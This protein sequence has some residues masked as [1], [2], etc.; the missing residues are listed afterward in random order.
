LGKLYIDHDSEPHI[1]IALQWGGS[2]AYRPVV[3]TIGNNLEP[4]AS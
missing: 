4:V 2:W 1:P 3:L